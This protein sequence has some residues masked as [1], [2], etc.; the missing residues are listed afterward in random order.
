[1]KFRVE[2]QSTQREGGVERQVG[3][4]MSAVAVDTEAKLL[5]GAP[6]GTQLRIEGFLDKLGKGRKRV[7]LH[8]IRIEFI[9]ET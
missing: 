3:C 7:V 4:E 6:L 1:M 8:A 5:A 9:A 2:H